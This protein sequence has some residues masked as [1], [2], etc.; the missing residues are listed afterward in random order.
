MA[1]V[2]F[3]AR[4]KRAIARTLR[5]G[6]LLFGPKAADNMKHRIEYSAELLALNPHMGKLEPE[7]TG[8]TYEYR[9]FVVHEHFKMIY[10]LD[11][12]RDTIYIVHFWDVRR[13]PQTLKEETK[14]TEK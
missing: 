12:E 8:I 5:N 13:E 10:R 7:L 4:A 3:K 6:F 1:V 9:S 11:E 2:K 14:I